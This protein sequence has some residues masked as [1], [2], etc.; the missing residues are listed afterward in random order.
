MKRGLGLLLAAVVALMACRRAGATRT[1]EKQTAPPARLT[2]VTERLSLDEL[3]KLPVDEA[4]RRRE[5]VF[6]LRPDRRFLIALG[7]LETLVVRTSP[8]RLRVSWKGNAWR[9]GSSGVEIGEVPELVGYSDFRRVLSSRARALV[10]RSSGTASPAGGAPAPELTAIREGLAKFDPDGAIAALKSIDQRWQASP[11]PDP[12]LAALAAQAYVLLSLQGLDTFEMADLLRGRALALLALS[13]ALGSSPDPADEA[14]LAESLGYRPDAIRIAS[15]LPVADPVRRFV[16]GKPQLLVDAAG[17]DGAD[18]QTRYL[19]LLALGERRDR[20]AWLEFQEAQFGH[21]GFSLPVLRAAAAL[22]SFEMDAALG[23]AT[24]YAALANLA[25]PSA[26]Q[27]AA[28]PATEPEEPGGLTQQLVE[29]FIGR[30]RKERRLESAGLV[31]AFESSLATESAAAHGPLWDT[32][33]LRAWHRGSFYSGLHI[34]GRRYLDQLSTVEGTRELAAYLQDSPEGPAAQFAR[35]YGGLSSILSGGQVSDQ[36]FDDLV[37]LNALGGPAVQRA[38]QELRSVYY[39]GTSSSAVLAERVAGRLDARP[40][41]VAY[42]LTIAAHPLQDFRM[43]DRLC[44]GWLEQGWNEDTT[45]TGHCLWFSGDTRGFAALL[46]NRQIDLAVRGELLY[47]YALS[48]GPSEAVCR[49]KF[50]DLAV[51]SGYSEIAVQGWSYYLWKKLKDYAGAQRA[52]ESWLAHHGP[53]E[54]LMW[55]VFRGRLARLISLQGRHAEAWRV[56]EPA[57]ESGQGGV[58]IWAAEILIRLG[59][60]DDAYTL[61][62][63]AVERYPDGAPGRAVLAEIL[64]RTQRYSEAAFVLDPTEESYKVDDGVFRDELAPQFAAVFSKVPDAG[65]E[66]AFA[67]LQAQGIR[68]R[69]IAYLIPP[70]AEAGRNDLAF[71]LQSSLSPKYQHLWEIADWKLEGFGY[72]EEAKGRPEAAAWIQRSIPAPQRESSLES[73]FNKKAWNLLWEAVPAAEE[74][75][76]SE[77]VWLLRAG[78]AAADPSVADAHRADLLDHYREA[79]PGD[80]TKTI[81]RHLLGLE[82]RNAVL[83]ALT[84]PDD[85]CKA[86]YFFGLQEIAGGRYEEASDWY[87]LVFDTCGKGWSWRLLSFAE[88]TLNKWYTFDENLRR[89]ATRKVW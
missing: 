2:I 66:S 36:H 50:R 68:A 82:D 45:T 28:E 78:A 79:K 61:A 87:Q 37:G 55:Y 27:A 11:R 10:S 71:R 85:R 31:R 51:E 63:R 18:R 34:L 41:N 53:S 24:I 46:G 88:S 26:V 32:H 17:R 14:L 80:A 9:L 48:E 65:V 8:A 7:E 42:M 73:F 52:V 43:L 44:Q 81:G 83:A 6:R 39:Q 35:W 29:K 60:L 47:R 15:V 84:T 58:M 69:R 72:L 3:A 22:Q 76:Q 12:E 38:A 86:A 70:L 77:W 64:W 21:E 56:V 1:V 5:D 30:I 49:A 13:E 59:R 33:A 4:R 89:A 54:G 16:S 75:K 20:Q 74:P 23:G 25:G 57:L 40:A 67:A 62:R 19:A